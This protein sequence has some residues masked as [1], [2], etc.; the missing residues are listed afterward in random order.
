MIRLIRG[1]IGSINEV[2]GETKNKE[3]GTN[4]NN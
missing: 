3:Q 1:L 2:F 4:K